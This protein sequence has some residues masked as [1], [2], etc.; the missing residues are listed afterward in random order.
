MSMSAK[1]QVKES[2]VFFYSLPCYFKVT[3]V[4]RER[5]SRKSTTRKLRQRRNSSSRHRS[6]GR[7]TVSFCDRPGSRPRWPVHVSAYRSPGRPV[8][9]LL[10]FLCL[11]FLVIDFLDFLSLPTHINA[12]EIGLRPKFKQEDMN[13]DPRRNGVE[14]EIAEVHVRFLKYEIKKGAGYEPRRMAFPPRELM[15]G[16]E[17]EKI[18]LRVKMDTV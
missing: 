5:K 9:L 12:V 13:I 14:G 1:L 7:S 8:S 3:Y 4:G 11:G 17:E 6:T 10:F 15:H 2:R 16:A 18:S